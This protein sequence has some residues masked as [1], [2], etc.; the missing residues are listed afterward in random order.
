VPP[1]NPFRL[2]IERLASR[3]II[4]GYTCGGEDEPCPGVYFRPTTIT[5]RG[6]M[7]K[8]AANSFFPDCRIPARQE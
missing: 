2:P 4:S 5:T 8:I 6:Q 1:G 3:G 7:A